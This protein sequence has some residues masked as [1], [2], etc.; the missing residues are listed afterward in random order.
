MQ[1]TWDVSGWVLSFALTRSREV[2]V[3]AVAALNAALNRRLAVW[4]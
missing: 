1:L 4:I 3:S 2:L